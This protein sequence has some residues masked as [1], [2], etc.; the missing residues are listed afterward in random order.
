MPLASV[1]VEAMTA[2][3][4]TFSQV[5]RLYDL[6]CGPQMIDNGDPGPQQTHL[7]PARPWSLYRRLRPEDI[8]AIVT[9]FLTG[10]R[11]V[12]L[13]VRFGISRSSVKRLLRERDV[14]RS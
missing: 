6:V 11:Q 3:S 1:S 13:A 2:Y 4:N 9:G 12:D 8:D 7:A 10:Q 5:K 14:R